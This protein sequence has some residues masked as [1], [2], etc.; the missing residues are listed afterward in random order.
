MHL[1]EQCYSELR[2]TRQHLGTDRSDTAN[3]S[4]RQSSGPWPFARLLFSEAPGRG[5]SRLAWAPADHHD[6]CRGLVRQQEDS[7]G[8][9][10]IP[11]L[12]RTH[13]ADLLRCSGFVSIPCP[14]PRGYRPRARPPGMHAP[15]PSPLQ[16]ASGDRNAER[17]EFRSSRRRPS[18][19]PGPVH[20]MLSVP[21]SLGRCAPT[22]SADH[23]R[24]RRGRHGRRSRASPR[25]VGV[26]ND[27]GTDR[28]QHQAAP[29]L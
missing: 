23:D 6:N 13:A 17:P 16:R 26:A 22:Q 29:A 28:D 9:P 25:A 27:D 10:H 14:A 20:G 21:R 4:S 15:G 18:T 24:A 3:T 1:T 8:H 7:G 11:A 12:S 2:L 5:R 19:Q